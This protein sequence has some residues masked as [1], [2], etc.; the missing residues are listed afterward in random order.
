VKRLLP[1]IAI[2]AGAVALIAASSADEWSPSRAAAKQPTTKLKLKRSPYGKVLFSGGYAMYLF[3]RDSGE[4]S[5][6][7]GP[8]A[9]AWPPLAARGELEGGRGVKERLIGTTTRPD[10]SKQVTYAGKP[11]YGY[12]DDPRG[13]VLCHDVEEFGGTWFAVRKS[14]RPAP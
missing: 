3:T 8:C 14:G 2:A 11:L 13:Q 4:R 1:L 12:V 6:C 7:H 9:E 5:E 10:G